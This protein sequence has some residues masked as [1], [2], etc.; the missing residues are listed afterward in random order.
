[1]VQ[2]II[3][4]PPAPAVLM[5]E[6]ALQQQQPPPISQLLDLLRLQLMLHCQPL[7]CW[8]GWQLQ[9]CWPG[10]GCRGTFFAALLC[11]IFA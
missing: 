9:D 5:Q 4:A 2:L 3:V 6:P 11:C 10:N 7:L 8:S 1:M